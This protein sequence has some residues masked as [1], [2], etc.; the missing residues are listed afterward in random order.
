MDIRRLLL[1]IG[2]L[3]IMLNGCGGEQIVTSAKPVKHITEVQPI[4]QT[5]NSVLDEAD[6]PVVEIETVDEP[7]LPETKTYRVTAY[8]PCEICCGKWGKNRPVGEDGQPIVIGAW[9]VA[10]SD[11]YSCASPMAF[12]TQV[13]LEGL[14]TV[15]VQDRTAQWIV[16]KYGEDIIDLYMTN[17]EEARKFGVQYIEGVIK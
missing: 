15:E 17:H 1:V 3:L 5:T 2:A 10:L 12:G 4:I 8:C 11:G 13:E 16:N 9:G 6:E 14:G 7:E